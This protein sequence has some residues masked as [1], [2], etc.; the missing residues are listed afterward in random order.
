MRNFLVLVSLGF[1]V[2]FMASGC[3]LKTMGKSVPSALPVSE[4]AG[5][6]VQPVQTSVPKPADP[7]VWDFG[8]IKQGTE[9]NH[10][11]TITNESQQ[12]I[13]IKDINTSCGCTASEVKKKDLAPGESTEI[14][15]TFKSSGYSGPVQQFVYVH[16]DKPEDPILKLTIKAE[17]IK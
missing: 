16:T 6:V 2:S 5:N 12:P 10:V 11:F 17:V 7:F 1:V 9:V 15:V 8:Q 14:G 4:T 3:A 13:K